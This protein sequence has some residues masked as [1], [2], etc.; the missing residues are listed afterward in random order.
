M[1]GCMDY[2][3][4]Q[5]LQVAHTTGTL[6]SGQIFYCDNLLTVVRIPL[7]RWSLLE[8]MQFLW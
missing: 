2:L 8:L 4:E 7:I 1:V 6:Y 3:T 5:D